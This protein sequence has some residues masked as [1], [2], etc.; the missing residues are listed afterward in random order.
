MSGPAIGVM[1]RRDMPPEMLPVFA[2]AVEA[3]GMDELWIVEDL[4]F[5]G[6]ISAAGVAL[7]LTERISV[8]IG[9]LPA[10]VRNA[11]YAA[12]D[13]ATL[14]RIF[15]G[16]LQIGLGHGVADWIRQ[17]GSMPRSQ[18]GALEEVTSA[19]RALLHG[20][21]VDVRGSYVLLD[22][23]RLEH[24]PDIVPPVSLGV[25]GPKS[26]ALSGRV[27]DG[28]ILVELTGPALV[29]HNLGIIR[30]A[31]AGAGR[32]DHQ[33]LIS[34]FAYW[35]QGADGAAVRAE[36]KPMLA[37]RI[38]REGMRDLI[39]PGFADKAQA[40]LDRGGVDL[41]A[42]EM[43]DAWLDEITVTGTPEQCRAAIDRLGEAGVAHIAL[44]PPAN[45]APET[46][47]EWSRDLAA[48]R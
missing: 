26:L 40:L 20:E 9:I 13:L 1:F 39:A 32:G 43:P 42:R 12:M 21:E 24:P 34:T 48:T 15:P 33:H 45:T 17:V 19:I 36:L 44:V 29:R 47:K 18:L 5:N 31:M 16:R 38:A 2:R 7:A 30:D 4:P 23:V 6:G 8:G 37:E 46:I 3:G 27:A 22:K 35:N 10:V 25:T 14:A 41:L 11:A 28:T